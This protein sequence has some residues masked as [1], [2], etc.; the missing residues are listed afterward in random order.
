MRWNLVGW[1]DEVDG[2]RVWGRCRLEGRREE[3]QFDMALTD[4]L[5]CQRGYVEPGAY[6]SFPNGFLLVHKTIFTTFDLEQAEIEA[7]RML[8]ALSWGEVA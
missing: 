6:V 2:G 3:F 5:E 8:R 7:D 1:I 4:V